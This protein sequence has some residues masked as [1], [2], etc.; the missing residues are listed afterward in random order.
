MSEVYQPRAKRSG[1]GRGCCG[2]MMLGFLLGVGAVVMVL[3]SVTGYMPGILNRPFGFG[4]GVAVLDVRGELN[5]ERPIL[6]NLERLTDDPNV[7]ALVVRV[8]SPGGIVTVMEEV[9]E[10]LIRV[11]KERS[12]PVVASMGT[13]AASGGYFICLAADRIYTN[14]TSLTGSIGAAF[15]YYNAQELLN[16]F[17]VEHLTIESG[18]FKGAGSMA[19]PLSERERELLQG[20]VDDIEAT[21]VAV[22]EKSRSMSPEK[23]AAIADGRVFTGRQ[24]VE[25]GLADETG[26][27]HEAVEHAAAEAGLGEDYRVIRIPRE[28][29]IQFRWLDWLGSLGTGYSPFGIVPKYVL[30]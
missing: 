17:G 21:F 28:T 2:F 15:E 16:R 9:Y 27:L 13:V 6:E 26:D 24:A 14:A 30:R 25:L 5:D 10:A 23:V 8:D 20:V 3:A 1:G 4:P 7:K 29:H 12:I 22:V 11:K 19:E 18:P